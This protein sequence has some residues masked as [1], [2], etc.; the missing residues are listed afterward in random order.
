MMMWQT[1]IIVSA[2]AVLIVC[3]TN[4]NAQWTQELCDTVVRL[5]PG[6]GQTNGQ[7]PVFFPRNILSGPSRIATEFV[8]DTDPREICSIG[9]GGSIVLGYRGAYIV[10]GP[11]ADFIVVENAFRYSSKRVY[12]EPAMVEVSRDGIVWKAFPY[13]SATLI[14]C[15]GVTPLGDAFDLA[16]IGV[17]TI[18]WIRITDVTSIVI[19]NPKHVYYDPTLT[20]FDLDVVIGLHVVPAAFVSALTDIFPTSSVRIDAPHASTVRVYNSRGAV[21]YSYNIA[22]GVMTLDLAP[23]PAGGYFVV[24]DD[25]NSRRTLKVLR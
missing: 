24:L 23:L 13:D 14:G 8:P 25:G 18:R 1:N 12:S 5:T 4:T 3:T 20:G 6:T 9:L 16:T 17:D 2:L 7:G 11:G 19:N 10:D 21:V 15:A 22:A